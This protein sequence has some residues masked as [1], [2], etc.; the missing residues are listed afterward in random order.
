ML[1]ER[2]V[3]ALEGSPISSFGHVSEVCVK[4]LKNL[5]VD[6]NTG[7]F[8]VCKYGGWLP[9]SDRARLYGLGQIMQSLEKG[10]GLAGLEN[11]E[12][13][14]ELMSKFIQLDSI[15]GEKS[16][17]YEVETDFVYLCHWG[18]EKS[19]ISHDK[20]PDFRTSY[21]FLNWCFHS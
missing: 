8:D 18:E 11:P 19:M 13:E 17:Y 10:W 5:G 15:E 21:D 9:V 16:F 1:E 3:Q 20:S 14:K 12:L 2:T 7:F 4:F 6:Q